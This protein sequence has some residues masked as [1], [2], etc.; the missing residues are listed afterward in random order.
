MSRSQIQKF[1]E[2]M[3]SGLAKI[4]LEAEGAVKRVS[5]IFYE[6]AKKYKIS[7]KL[8]LVTAQKEQSAIT[9]ENLTEDQKTKLMG[10]CI[11]PGSPCSGKYLGIFAQ[12]DAAAWQFRQYLEKAG[13][14]N[15]QKGKTSKTSDNETVTPKNQSTAGLYNYTPYQGGERGATISDEGWG[16]NFLFWKVWSGW[17]GDPTK[18]YSKKL[19]KILVGAGLGGGPQVRVINGDGNPTATQ[20]YAFNLEFDGGVYVAAGDIDG[21]RRDEIIV[22]AGWSAPPYVRI[23]DGYPKAQVSDFLAYNEKFKGGVRVA[24]G[25]VDGDGV[26]EIITGAGFDGSSKIKIFNNQGKRKYKTFMAYDR[27]FSG[28]VYVAAA[29]LNGDKKAEILV[30]A[31]EGGGPQVKIFNKKGKLKRAFFA[32]NPKDRFGARVAAVDV[33]GDKKSEILI[34]AGYGDKPWVRLFSRFGKKRKDFFAFDKNFKGG[35]YIAGG[36]TNGDGRE[37]IVTSAGLGGGPQVRV[38]SP[39]GQK[40]YASFFV[41]DQKFHGGV[42]VATVK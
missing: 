39:D 28:G 38:F 14:Y 4:K 6:A 27:E 16:G 36:D 11:Y 37:E 21:D 1:L 31:G 34:S 40:V 25:D 24:V 2:S 7:Q 35:I 18:S 12:I 10:Y 26:D 13:L 29:D 17:F 8:L 22:G 15:F 9:T 42:R 3:G 33:N 23:F 32:G 5:D 41:F 30:S 20:F 19:A